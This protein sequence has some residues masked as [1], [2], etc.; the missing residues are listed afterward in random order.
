MKIEDLLLLPM[1]LAPTPD[2]GTGNDK[3]AECLQEAISSRQ[4]QEGIQALGGPAPVAGVDQRPSGA[5]PEMVDAVLSRLEIFQEALARPDLSLKSLDFLVQALEK[6]STH[7]DSLARSLSADDPLRQIV[8]EAAALTW[9][10]SS[11]FKRGD[12]L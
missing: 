2:A 1:N 6:D 12:Y 4:Q 9:A 11:K 7:L 8:E 5:A 3:F 10:E